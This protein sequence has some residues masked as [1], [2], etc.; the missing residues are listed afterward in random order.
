MVYS[1]EGVGEKHDQLRDVPGSFEKIKKS[2][3]SLYELKKKYKNLVID[4]NSVF[5]ANSQD[6]LLDTIKYLRT[7]FDFDNISV[8]YARGKIPNEELKNVVKEKYIEINNYIE[9]LERNK[10]RRV[11]SNVWRGVNAITRENIIQV[12][13]ENKFVNPCVAGK[14]IVVISETGD[15]FP[16]EILT[17]KLGNLKEENFNLK[18]ILRSRDTKKL[19]KWIKDSKCKCTF[20]CAASAS[21]VWNPTNYFKIAKA[22]VKS[23]VRDKK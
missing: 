19:T 10:E 20:E 22:S 15:V 7:N 3:K 17:D 9:K 16:C 5:T 8:T 18:K 12:G 1:I 14:K 21:V 2:F 13:F 4:S 6:S 23:F 11:F